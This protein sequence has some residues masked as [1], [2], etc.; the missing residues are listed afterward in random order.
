MHACT[1][2]HFQSIGVYFICSQPASALPDTRT[3]TCLTSSSWCIFSWH[4][5]EHVH[6]P[7]L[8]SSS[9]STTYYVSYRRWSF[10]DIRLIFSASIFQSSNQQSLNAYFDSLGNTYHKQTVVSAWTG[11]SMICVWL[12]FRN[13]NF[14]HEKQ[15]HECMCAW[16]SHVVYLCKAFVHEKQWHDVYV[17]MWNTNNVCVFT[18]N[19]NISMAC[20]PASSDTIWRVFFWQEASYIFFM[21]ILICDTYFM[22]RKLGVL[23]SCGGWSTISACKWCYYA[24]YV[25]FSRALCV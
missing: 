3:H 12:W 6:C 8:K 25:C 4:F 7:C 21:I 13:I 22:R 24:T 16:K 2:V 23:K 5:P 10:H 20:E 17:C 11:I 18:T 1:H 19:T 14:V 15:W 9:H